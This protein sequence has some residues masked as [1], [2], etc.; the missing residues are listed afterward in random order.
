MASRAEPPQEALSLAEARWVR[1]MV[2][3]CADGVWHPDG[4]AGHAEELPVDAGLIA[5]IRRWQEWYDTESKDY[6]PPE[7]RTGQFDLAAFAA[8]GLAIARAVKAA[9]PDWTVIYFDEAACRL[10]APRESFE[11]EII[12]PPP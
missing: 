12:L 5:R 8:E 7:E 4:C 11:Y 1:I 10:D 3:Y 6:L 9:L 2:D